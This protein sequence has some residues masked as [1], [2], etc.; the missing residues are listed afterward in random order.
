[1]KKVFVSLLILFSINSMAMSS[2]DKSRIASYT[3]ILDSDKRLLYIGETTFDL[4][5]NCGKGTALTVTSA[6]ADSVPFI[7]NIPDMVIHFEERGTFLGATSGD[8]FFSI[9]GGLVLGGTHLLQET[10]DFLGID[11]IDS[12]QVLEDLSDTYNATKQLGR[13][14]FSENGYCLNKLEKLGVIIEA[15]LEDKK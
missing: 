6:I 1:M 14:A 13:E 3:K 15:S 11:A 12:N 10:L 9:F 2:S 5:K 7:T 4:V 8:S